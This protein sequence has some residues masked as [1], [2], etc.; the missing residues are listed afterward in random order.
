MPSTTK[1]DTKK[2]KNSQR[3]MR[4]NMGPE[5]TGM[6]QGGMARLLNRHL[7]H[8]GLSCVPPAAAKEMGRLSQRSARWLG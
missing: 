1:E 2:K 3:P 4:H 7:S 5:T 6:L 8:I